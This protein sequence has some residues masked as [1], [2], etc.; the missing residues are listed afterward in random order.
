MSYL[1]STDILT[2][3]LKKSLQERKLKWWSWHK[4]NPLVYELFEKYTFN[5]VESTTRI[6]RLLIG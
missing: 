3:S 5:A 1:E 2:N 4:K 6:G